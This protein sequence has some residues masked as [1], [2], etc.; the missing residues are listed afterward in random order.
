MRDGSLRMELDWRPDVTGWTG[1]VGDC[2]V[3]AI[4]RKGD[5]WVGVGRL[6]GLHW[7][8][9][10]DKDPGAV[11]RDVEAWIRSHRKDVVRSMLSGGPGLCPPPLVPP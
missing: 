2:A 1:F 3:L 4:R 9:F 6:P 7:P 5:I 11:Q 10:C 8:E